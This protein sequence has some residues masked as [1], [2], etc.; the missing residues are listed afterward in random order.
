MQGLA[1]FKTSAASLPRVGV[2]LIRIGRF[3]IIVNGADTMAA[4]A[5]VSAEVTPTGKQ[6]APGS[7][8][9]LLR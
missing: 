7:A 1:D 2:H 9:W 4:A 8:S 6:K 5:I 3:H